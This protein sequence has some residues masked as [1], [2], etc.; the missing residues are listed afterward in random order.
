[1]S[2]PL[3][4]H[5]KLG[6]AMYRRQ[7]FKP[8]W[9][10]PDRGGRWRLGTVLG[11]FGN[12]IHWG[13]RVKVQEPAFPG[14]RCR[15]RVTADGGQGPFPLTRQPIGMGPMKAGRIWLYDGHEERQS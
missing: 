4:Y 14:W 2:T 5:G 13:R 3:G 12:H 10:A 9:D 11:V 6:R 7:S 15:C 1:M 8:A